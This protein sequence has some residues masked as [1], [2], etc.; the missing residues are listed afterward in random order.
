MKAKDVYKYLLDHSIDIWQHTCDGLITGDPEKEVKKVATCFK[1]TAKLIDRA[2][3]EKFDMII[4]HEPVFSSG[5]SRE[6]AMPIDLE[7]WAMLDHSNITVYRFH[8]HAHNTAPDYI[9]QGFINA[10]GLDISHKHQNESLGVCRY[11]LANPLTVRQ[12]AHLTEE[13]LGAEFARVVGDP[14]TVVK[15]LCLGLGAV[16]MKQI[17]V[18]FD[19]GCDLFVT[20]EVPEVCVCEY[21]RDACFFGHQKAVIILGH[22]TS[23]YQGMNLLAQTLN[24]NLIHAEHLHGGEVYSKV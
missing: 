4:T 10:L 7:K 14:D 8:D 24:K 12:I 5:D 23:E 20:G 6:E 18:L 15:T 19:P 16:G 3:R 1:L 9:H 11:D 2:A 17:K 21:V 13:K 22:C